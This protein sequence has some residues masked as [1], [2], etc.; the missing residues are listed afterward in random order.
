MTIERRCRRA[1]RGG[2][3]TVAN[4]A[5]AAENPFEDSI[6]SSDRQTWRGRGLALFCGSG[7]AQSRRSLHPSSV[8]ERAS[9]G[10]HRD[11]TGRV[12]GA[13]QP[14]AA[15]YGITVQ[16]AGSAVDSKRRDKAIGV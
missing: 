5:L 3:H 9:S 16:V 15:T 7:F 8:S 1:E 11:I 2:E 6:A 10:R 13:S 4:R 14:V 12:I